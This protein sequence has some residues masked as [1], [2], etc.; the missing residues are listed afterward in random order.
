MVAGLEVEGWIGR[1]RGSMLEGD[2]GSMD[3]LLL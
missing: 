2:G 1:G 3:R